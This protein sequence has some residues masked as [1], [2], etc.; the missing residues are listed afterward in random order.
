MEKKVKFSWDEPKTVKL[1]EAYDNGKGA[2]VETLAQ[3][4]GTTTKSVVG[5]LVYEKVYVKQEKTKKKIEKDEG[6]TK[7]QILEALAKKIDTDGAEG[8][9]K[10][11]L[12]E[13]A[14]ALEVKLPI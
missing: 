13:V 8:A 1:L 11:F 12:K 7:G 4:F 10:P 6:P 2:S 9:S 14:K 3:E 5:K